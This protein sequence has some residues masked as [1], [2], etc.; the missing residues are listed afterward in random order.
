VS[1]ASDIPIMMLSKIASTTI[2]MVLTGEGADELLGGY[3]KHRAE[4]W[5]ERYHRVI[6]EKLH[7]SVIFPLVKALPYGARRLKVASSAA[8]ERDLAAR[9]RV[10]FGGITLSER[11]ALLGYSASSAPIDVYPFSAMIGSSMRRTLF[12]DQTSWLPDNLL[13]RGDRMM[14]AGSVEGR[15]P[16]LDIKLAELVAHFPDRFLIGRRGGKAILRATMDK[17]LPTKI[18]NRKKIGFRVPFN[19]WFRGQYRDHIRDLLTSSDSQVAKV[20][21]SQIVR[22]LVEGHIDGRQ[23]NEKALWS[24]ANLEMF[25]R[26]FKLTVPLSEG[27]PRT[28]SELV[29][30]I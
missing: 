19:E 11:D 29:V 13:E 24:L 5:I 22:S 21:N 15:M 28:T 20:C 18:V 7:S 12:F 3:P 4:P 17:L 2:K 8:N 6:P 23:N 14:M 9:M 25:L 30:E 10:W 27:R 26:M 1:E 16:F